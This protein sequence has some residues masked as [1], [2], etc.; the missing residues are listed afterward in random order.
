MIKTSIRHLQHHLS[1]VMRSVEHG[2]EV[3]ITRRNRVVAKLV[4]V[5]MQD[6]KVDWPDFLTRAKSIVQHPEGEPASSIVM[7]DREETS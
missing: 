6:E 5:E 7:G 3:L 1:D 2:E 4:P